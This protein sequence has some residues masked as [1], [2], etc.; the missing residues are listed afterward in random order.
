M[1]L[2]TILRSTFA[3]ST[4]LTACGGEEGS[5]MR[6]GDVTEEA[7]DVDALSRSCAGSTTLRG[8]DVSYYQGTIDWDRVKGDGVEYAFIR[9]SDGLGYRDSQYA[10]NWSEA[11]RAGVRRG[12]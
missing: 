2:G 9:V 10:R 11:R 4:V 12:T 1:K 5:E 3:L 8:I 7:T 6:A